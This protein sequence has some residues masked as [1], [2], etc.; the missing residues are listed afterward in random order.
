MI[1]KLLDIVSSVRFWLITL[2]AASVFA[3]LVQ[4]N[5]FEWK[6]LFD[7][8]ALWLATVAGIGTID[9]FGESVGK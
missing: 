8:V 7:T 1:E 9:K 5:G 3:G 4:V 2:G 6:T